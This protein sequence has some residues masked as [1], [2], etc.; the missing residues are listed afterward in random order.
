M[1]QNMVTPPQPPEHPF[2]LWEGFRDPP[3]GFQEVLI[4]ALPQSPP[5]RQELTSCSP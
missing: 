2:L 5:G 4:R 1:Q 3:L